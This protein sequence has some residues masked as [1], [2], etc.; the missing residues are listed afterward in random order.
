[1]T[2]SQQD[3]N[4]YSV[5]LIQY[6]SESASGSGSQLAGTSLTSNGELSGSNLR[7]GSGVYWTAGIFIGFPIESMTCSPSE[8]PNYSWTTSGSGTFEATSAACQPQ[9][10]SEGEGALLP[11]AVIGTCYAY[12][13]SDRLPAKT[14]SP[15]GAPVHR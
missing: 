7:P 5:P 14:N 4:I 8:Y 3:E 2:P 12:T 13:H 10:K 1:M 15:Y 9:C 6:G 11:H